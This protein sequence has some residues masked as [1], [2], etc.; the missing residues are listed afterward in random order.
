MEIWSWCPIIDIKK[1][2][3]ISSYGRIKSVPRAWIGKDNR[4]G[5]VKSKDLKVTLQNQK[6][7]KKSGT[8]TMQYG[9]VKLK[10]SAFKID[11]RIA[12]YKLVAYCFAGEI[13]SMPL[14][15]RA[16]HDNNAI[17]NIYTIGKVQEP[18]G[19][20]PLEKD[21]QL[22]EPDF[23]TF[24]NIVEPMYSFY[25]KDSQRIKDKQTEK[26]VHDMIFKL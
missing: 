3:V 17:W 21:I 23:S 24:K 10:H 8:E 9:T 18:I 15:L 6:I 7:Y 26:D 20:R 5:H 16:A 25:A 12:L 19:K 14:Q 4:V 13:G 11:V 1:C 22:T 2:Y